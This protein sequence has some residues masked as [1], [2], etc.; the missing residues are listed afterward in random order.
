MREPIRMNEGVILAFRTRIREAN[1]R[2]MMTRKSMRK[3]AVKL[4]IG[5]LAVV[6]MLPTALIGAS[7][8]SGLTG[9]E[10]H[11]AEKELTE[12]QEKGLIQGFGDG[13]LKPDQ[14]IT[15]AEFITLVNRVFGFTATGN[16]PFKDVAADS[17]YYSDIQ[18]A[19]AAGYIRGYDDG[20]FRPDMT[21]NRQEAAVILA[22]VFAIAPSEQPVDKL[23]DIEQ[24]AKWSRGSVRALV[25]QGFV[26]G[27]PDKTFRPASPITRAEAV[28]LIGSLSGEIINIAGTYSNLTTRNAVISKAGVELSDSVI[29][30]DLFVTA[31]V[32]EGDITLNNVTV[33][34][35]LR[36]SGGG[37]N[38][39]H[40]NDS[41]IEAIIVDKKNGTVRIVVNGATNVKQTF[42][43]SGVKLE[44]GN[45]V[46]GNGYERVILEER[47]TENAAV[48][49][50]GSFGEVVTRSLNEPELKLLKG[51]IRKLVI[52]RKIK[53]HA[54]QGTTIQ[55]LLID[56]DSIITITGLGNVTVN[57]GSKS[58]PIFKD[59]QSD[60]PTDLPS[61]PGA[62][63]PTFREVSVHDPSIV[64]AGN[65]YYVFGSHIEAAK[66][67]DLQHW[68]RFT[69]GY[70]TTGNALFGDLSANLAESF[71]WAG[72]NDADNLG[73]F[74]VWAPDVL[75]NADYVNE[76]GSKGAY[77]M[78]YSVSSTY[79]RS[80]IGIA[81]SRSIEGPYEYV[82]TII[83]SGFTQEDATDEDSV[84]NKKW[85]NTNIPSLIEDGVL[86]EST[87]WYNGDGSYKNSMYPNAIDANL[88]YDADG[89]LHMTYG[90]WSGG[91]FLLD[92]D[93][94]TGRPIYPGEDGT[95][96][97]GRLIDRYFGTK[98]AGGYGKSGEGP[99]V[100]YD[101]ATGYY[102]L[103][104]TYGWL[105]ADGA[106]NMRLFRATSPEGPYTDAMN[107][108]AVL[109][110][111]TD[112]D[113]YGNK[114][115]GNYLFERKV[116]D[117]GMGIGT[118]YVSSGHNS[119][120]FDEKTGKKFIVFHTRFPGTGEFHEVRVHQLFM[121]EDNW[122]VVAPYRYTGEKLGK[123]NEKQ[124]AGEYR[125]LNHGK[126][127]AVPTVK[128]ILIRLNEDNTISGD[129][130]GSWQLT[131]D[132]Y[133]ELTIG[134]TVYKG[135][136]AKLW[137]TDSQSYVMTFT[138]MSG[139]GASI[140]GSKLRDRTDKQLV[141]DV[142]KGIQ[143]GDLTKVVSD[144]TLP[145]EGARYSQISWSTSH[146]SV[147]TE[148]GVVTRPEADAGSAT[149][150]LTATV[151]KGDETGTRVFTVNVLPSQLSELAARYEFEDNL[152]ES[153]D[154]FG[155]GTITG[156]RIDHTGG[157]ITYE[158][159]MY[160]DAAA[161]DGSSGVKLPNGLIAS[162]SYSVSLWL[163]P[164]TLNTYT[165]AFF[166]ARD[167]NNWISLLPQGPVGNQTMLWSGSTVWYDVTAGL[168]IKAQ[169]WSHIAFTVESGTAKLYVN[170][171][172]K[173]SGTGFPDIFT[174][175]DGS[176]S[177]GVNWWD[178]PYRGLI[179]DLRI[180]EGNLTQQE[181]NDLV[182]DSSVMVESVQFD[183]TDK[184]VFA[185]NT[186]TPSG[187]SV[188]PINAGNQQL[189]WS[190]A[191]DTVAT[192]DADTGTV[193]AVQAG[194]VDITATATDGSGATAT[195]TLEVVDEAIVHYSFEGDLTDEQGGSSG[196]ITGNKADN[197]GG[198]I[199]YDDGISGQAAVFNG[200]SGIRLP[201]GLIASDSYTV[202]MSVYVQ[203]GSQ[204]TPAFFGAQSGN[205][206]ISLVPRGP[207]SSQPTML[208]SGTTW[209]DAS[210]GMQ[211][212]IGEW[213]HVAFTV[214][215]GR[216]TVYVNGEAKFTGTG[217]PDVFTSNDA[218]FALGVNYWDTPFTGMIDELLIYN[219][220]L[221]AEQIAELG[222]AA[223]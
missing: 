43:L 153:L 211:I 84:I 213:A 104:V 214:E 167:G 92:I 140:W 200:S 137:D 121:N 91:I 129:V 142:L 10:Y 5:F 44:N 90:S 31:G 134:G 123:V 204:Y 23:T 33:K 203:Q 18:K 105:G 36:I 215:D 25:E 223:P 135:V 157:T 40:V 67:T 102:F 50:S 186:Y 75:W 76:D 173:Y 86:T 88:F 77:L 176:F 110:S 74:S 179:D 196:T 82:D 150:Q 93:K 42:V 30:G 165:T 71:D 101:K 145:L 210:T 115:I 53:L 187:V 180:Y 185:G 103:N 62:S 47:L 125:F 161:F 107:Q 39:I 171:I 207:G 97:D 113:P 78:Y 155:A 60:S 166:G 29:E 17:S 159:G 208:W 194:S 131:S 126:T 184:K 190:S 132:Y 38:S 64:K 15:R 100:R 216:I 57:S 7:P 79:I 195:Y 59:Q 193:S 54:E 164:E 55:D 52:E 26:S 219:A 168:T 119:L 122:P 69:N 222:A 4:L 19:V 45:N 85:T 188:S 148:Q 221:S 28:K 112:N 174:G 127:N 11:W 151:T 178:T 156:N 143:L 14:S 218:V 181:V 191:D 34:G 133:A 136:Y 183:F 116:G 1:D 220:A 21:I 87:A 202:S 217:F 99:Y 6:L 128:S 147:V 205:S 56:T 177:L 41:D 146:L 209:Y 109:P 197:T 199:T 170:G 24:L 63:T 212:P 95:T 124:I 114:L 83:Y 68:T 72:E 111:N 16:A 32:G 46:T 3:G 73:G 201:N 152:A 117:P 8:S 162:N 35:S 81:A 206:W 94:A 175:N 163:K 49:L 141:N 149:A 130:T 96:E 192:V 22:N 118:G 12:W 169:Q 138:A 27:Y 98:I 106:Y 89:K 182:F 172:L 2:T 37:P 160:G 144:L 51:L 66:S 108:D 158:D 58:K 189:L 65:T 154:G 9:S 13:S 198:T 20:T 139:E 120:Y 80:A 70:A 61:T 48:E